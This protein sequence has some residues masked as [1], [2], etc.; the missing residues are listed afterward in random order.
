[1]RPRHISVAMAASIAVPL[2]R[3]TSAPMFEHTSESEATA[4]CKRV[5]FLPEGLDWFD[6]FNLD[7]DESD[8]SEDCVSTTASVTAIAITTTTT[9]KVTNTHFF[10]FMIFPGGMLLGTGN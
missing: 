6:W 5:R 1:M 7:L 3:I 2:S 4:P 8:E 9:A 10:D